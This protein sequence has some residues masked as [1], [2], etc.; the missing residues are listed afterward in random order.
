MT[1]HN[2]RYGRMHRVERER[3]RLVVETG[4]AVCSRCSRPIHPHEP[5]DLD[6]ADGGGPRDYR[7]P[8]H[9]KCN[10]KTATWTAQRR[11]AV[12]DVHTRHVRSLGFD[13]PTW[14]SRYWGGAEPH[15]GCP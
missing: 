11:A 12:G 2:D 5:W 14:F 9:R 8:S 1:E 6:H 3:V 15:P 13:G 4:G 10:R 7:G